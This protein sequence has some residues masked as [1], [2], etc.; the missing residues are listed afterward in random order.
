MFRVATGDEVKNLLNLFITTGNHDAHAI[1]VMLGQK[2]RHIHDIASKSLFF[3][4]HA[5]R[6]LFEVI[7]EF[8][9]KIFTHY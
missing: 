3:K 5:V 6:G 1:S 8:W 2:L 9:L 7:I 4:S